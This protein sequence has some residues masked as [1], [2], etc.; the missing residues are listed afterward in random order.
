MHRP[1]LPLRMRLSL[2][3]FI[4]MKAKTILLIVSSALL[5][6]A[7]PACETERTTTTTTEETTVQHPVTTE[8]RTVRTY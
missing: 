7:L 1:S 6:A 3:P 5:L 2:T 8:T 4:F